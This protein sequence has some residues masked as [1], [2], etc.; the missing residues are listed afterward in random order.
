M[1]LKSKG[2]FICLLDGDDFFF[3]KIN[4]LLYIKP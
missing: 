4:Y 2:N 1:F 3:Q